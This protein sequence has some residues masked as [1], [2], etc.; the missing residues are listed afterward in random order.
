M[1][2]PPRVKPAPVESKDD[3]SS[4]YLSKARR[5]GKRLAPV[6]SLEQVFATIDPDTLRLSAREGTSLEFKES[7]NWAGKDRYAKTMAAFANNRGGYLL[8]G[9]TNSPRVLVGLAGA[10]FE[11][12]DE[13]IISGY[14][15][16]TFS[17]A[18][19]FEKYIHVEHGKPIGVIYVPPHENRPVVAIKNDGDIK[20]AEIYYRYKGRSDKIKFPELTALFEH[21]RERERRAWMDLFE[22]VS[23]IGPENTGVMDIVRGTI[24]GEKGSLLIDTALLPKLRFI[25]EGTF[26]E[27]GRPALKLIGD[28]RPVAV[29][30]RHAGAS[31]L[32]ITDDPTA[33]AVRE[34][35]ILSQYPLAYRD[36]TRA[37]EKRY[38]DFKQNDAFHEIRRPLRENPEYCHTRY[39]DPKRKK[40]R[41]DFYNPDIM[42]EFDKHY[43][44]R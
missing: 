36:L 42:S 17:P 44:K 40:I 18:I 37:L 33:P 2:E 28:V 20:E 26:T 21:T 31:G 14:L 11:N 35:T 25:K 32:R 4:E 16:G 39:L 6:I 5:H 23:K 7:F 3:V 13:A 41:K 27:R 30:G 9:V 15:N 29:T 12:L 34:E 38:A 8:F 24:E 1:R 43:T 19:A 22:R 10:G